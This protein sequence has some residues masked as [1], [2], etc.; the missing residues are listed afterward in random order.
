MRGPANRL[1]ATIL[2]TL[3]VVGVLA[4][5]SEAWAPGTDGKI[6]FATAPSGG[7]FLTGALPRAGAIRF[8]DY[9]SG[10]LEPG[11]IGSADQPSWSP[12]GE[13][14][15]Y[16]MYVRSGLG[17]ASTGI[18]LANADGSD[19]RPVA[20][21]SG[22]HSPVFSPNGPY[23]AFIVP[24]SGGGSEIERLNIVTGS[25]N[26]VA[27]VGAESADALAWSPDGSLIAFTAGPT[28][29]FSGTTGVF[30]VPSAGGSVRQLI[31]DANSV[32][33]NDL[34]WDLAGLNFYQGSAGMGVLGSTD[35][36]A[37]IPA[38]AAS[39]FEVPFNMGD[40]AL[41]P[42]EDTAGPLSD[43]VGADINDNDLDVVYAE[44]TGVGVG[45]YFPCC[46]GVP[47]QGVAWQPQPQSPPSRYSL[48]LRGNSAVLNRLSRSV[49]AL[50]A[51]PYGPTMCNLHLVAS[52]GRGGASSH[53]GDP[54]LGEA[55]ARVPA[56]EARDVTIGFTKAARSLLRAGKVKVI[57]LAL[58][59]PS[60]KTAAREDGLK[61]RRPSTAS[62]GCP[63]HAAVGGS[64]AISGRLTMTNPGRRTVLLDASSDLG[65]LESVLAGTA[66]NGSY[67]TKLPITTSGEWTITALW[68]GT[69]AIIP[70][71]AHC[72]LA[73]PPPATAVPTTLTLKC[74]ASL[75]ANSQLNVSGTME[76]AFKDA[77]IEITYGEPGGKRFGDTVTTDA[78]GAFSD[79]V[80]ASTPGT[81]TMQASVAGSPTYHG[82]QSPVCTTTVS[83]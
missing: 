60:G 29:I 50:V 72:H 23:I 6:A 31:T 63:A 70:A 25:L 49:L 73:V 20:V 42:F 61:V 41:G 75:G 24:A 62:I 43:F 28:S 17:W 15:A 78:T 38:S 80:L 82:S 48:V 44:F 36:S 39:S 74:P 71:R 21:S 55:T 68:A 46:D 64:A 47:I 83:G 3:V 2:A 27:T 81:W 79:S 18:G 66:R 30:V 65:G 5:V 57:D 26:S 33:L 76:P 19:Q 69:Q 45:Q 12:D 4:P 16:V 14:V 8:M 51:C 13:S 52:S 7:N 54:A 58:T 22:A 56:G 77:D 9:P 32:E 1:A 67:S 37:P 53:A 40:F 59:K 10:T 34:D 11:S 35:L